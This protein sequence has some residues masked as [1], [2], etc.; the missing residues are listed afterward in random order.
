MGAQNWPFA[1][2]AIMVMVMLSTVLI[3]VTAFNRL[4]QAS[5]KRIE[6]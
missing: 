2:A 3:A 4:G 5:L 1:A 6:G